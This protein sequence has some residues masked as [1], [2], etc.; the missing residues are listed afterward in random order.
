MEEDGSIPY[1]QKPNTCTYTKPDKSIQCLS[2]YYLKVHF[3]NVSPAVFMPSR[4][5]SV[6]IYSFMYY[7]HPS[8]L[9]F[10]PSLPK[11]Y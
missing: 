11:T 8:N 4:T 1:S 5:N 6:F 10:L 2:F 7:I 9:I 3:N